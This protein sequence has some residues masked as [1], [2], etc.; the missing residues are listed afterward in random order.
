MIE[1]TYK[2]SYEAGMSVEELS[3]QYKKQ[4]YIAVQ[5]SSIDLA[6]K[7]GIEQ[8]KINIAST[9]KQKGFDAKTIQA[10]TGL[11]LVLIDSL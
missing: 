3:L 11:S 4:K 1:S 5:K 6:R 8:N 7:K 2:T 10:I 9:M